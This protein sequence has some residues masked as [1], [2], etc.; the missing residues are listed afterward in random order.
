V[1]VV[2]AD[3]SEEWMLSADNVIELVALLHQQT[4]LTAEFFLLCLEVYW[5][6]STLLGC[7]Y[8]TVVTDTPYIDGN[9]DPK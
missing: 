8:T 2:S 1:V 5:S 7:F 9:C 3:N 4:D 6:F